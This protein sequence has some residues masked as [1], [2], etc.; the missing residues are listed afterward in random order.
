MTARGARQLTLGQQAIGLRSCFPNTTIS[1]KRDKLQ[2]RGQL[3]PT[4]DSNIYTV[5]VTYTL[6]DPPVIR[7]L[8]PE[9]V[10]DA[11]GKLPHYF[12]DDSLC[13]HEWFE[14]Q[15]SMQLIDT[16]LPW[17]VEW[18]FYYEIWRATGC[19][20]G[21]GDQDGHELHGPLE[22]LDA[23]PRRVRRRLS[24]ASGR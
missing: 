17:T 10:P 12:R 7:V 15:P 21:D 18:L 19:W 22:G 1:F 20:Y 2:W 14:W 6:G 9:L 23:L 3:Q 13:L 8:E 24:T 16:T 5:T 4:T 11:D